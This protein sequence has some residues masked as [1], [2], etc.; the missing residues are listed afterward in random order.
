MASEKRADLV[1]SFGVSCQYVPFILSL[2]TETYYVQRNEQKALAHLEMAQMW[3]ILHWMAMIRNTR[4]RTRR[5]CS[6]LGFVTNYE[7]LG[8][9]LN[10]SLPMREKRCQ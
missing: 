8:R 10:L 4:L 7:T 5:L 9:S 6:N 1:F 3:T 2:F